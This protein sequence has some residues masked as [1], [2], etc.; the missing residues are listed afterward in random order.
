MYRSVER[1]RGLWRRVAAAVA[2]AI[3]LQF[4]F[5]ADART[6]VRIDNFGQ[7]NADYYRGAQPKGS[8]YADLAG[9]GVRTIIDLQKDGDEREPDLVRAAGLRYFRIP[10]TTRVAP[11]AE[12]VG[13][14]LGLVT[15][16]DHQPV[17]VHCA[18]GRHRTGV[19]TAVYR[20]T[21]E[22][23]DAGRAFAEMKKYRYG[24][25]FLH[26]EFKKFV[27]AFE[28]VRATPSLGVVA[29]GVGE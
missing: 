7:V 3:A 16:P 12:Q 21:E 26:P 2:L 15:N 24:P 11:T 1:D 29:T 10:M 22:G 13:T 27:F 17:F 14:F 18:G 28:P 8:G 25:D 23:W 20:M 6:I 9:L 19:M 4:S 5:G